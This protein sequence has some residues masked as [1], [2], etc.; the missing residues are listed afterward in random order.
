M[1]TLHHPVSPGTSSMNDGAHRGTFDN[2]AISPTQTPISVAHTVDAERDSDEDIVIRCKPGAF[3]SQP[4]QGVALVA[5]PPEQA[6][7]AGRAGRRRGER[8]SDP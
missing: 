2:L 4:Q 1:E 3:R 8:S 6:R 5:T 7:R